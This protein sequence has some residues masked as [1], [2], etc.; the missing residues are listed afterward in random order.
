MDQNAVYY[1]GAVHS[2]YLNELCFWRV[3]VALLCE[4][5]MTLDGEVAVR[6]SSV[7]WYIVCNDQ[8]SSCLSFIH[9]SVST[10]LLLTH[11]QPSSRLCL[12]WWFVRGAAQCERAMSAS[13][14]LR[15]PATGPPT[16]AATAAPLLHRALPL[17][18][19]DPPS[20]DVIDSWQRSVLPS[21]SLAGLRRDV[22]FVSAVAGF[23]SLLFLFHRGASRWRRDSHF[24]RLW[25][26]W[27]GLQ[28]V[29]WLSYAVSTVHA[30]IAS[31]AGL[32]CLAHSLPRPAALPSASPLSEAVSWF[33][34]MSLHRLPPVLPAAASSSSFS[35]PPSAES[36]FSL[37]LSCAFSSSSL[38]DCSLL[39]TAAY[40]LVDLILCVAST[41]LTQQQQQQART[42]TAAD[43]RQV[44]LASP[45]TLVHHT[46]ILLAF[47]W[48]VHTQTGTLYMSALL[49]NELSTPLLN[50]NFF[51]SSAALSSSYRRL[52]VWNAA[53]L[54]AVF[55]LARVLW[56][57]LLLCHI[58]LFGWV[59]LQ[60]LWRSD[61]RW[62]M[63]TAVRWR[64]AALSALCCCHV[65]VN[66]VWAVQLGRAVY[67]KWSKAAVHRR[68][69]DI[70]SSGNSKHYKQL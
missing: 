41:T 42:S 30:V 21:D 51:L 48:G 68:E 6:V 46:V 20:L 16:T 54:L 64:C 19:S 14:A 39:V 61:S 18:L 23:A 12:Q 55:V 24:G 36:A 40:L 9:A 57:A 26:E 31:V 62:L 8:Q 4:V 37:A 63:P 29:E 27:S 2:T 35:S 50:A 58:F 34:R 28:R 45:L 38:R 13:S 66:A 53:L 70:G 7:V 56:N 3:S 5:E 67:R 52:Y 15:T 44:Q 1:V 10:T 17:L 65:A 47:G 32:A 25:S 60:P 33:V 11:C 43:G 49:V 22:L 59:E 69:L